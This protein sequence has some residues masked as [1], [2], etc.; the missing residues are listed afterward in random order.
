MV[1]ITKFEIEM[2]L[3]RKD[4]IEFLNDLK[5]FL[6]DQST[7]YIVR[8]LGTNMIILDRKDLE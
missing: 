7:N 1:N 3:S 5:E 4:R 6:D 8:L 2:N